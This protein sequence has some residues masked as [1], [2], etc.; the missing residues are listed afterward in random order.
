[1]APTSEHRDGQP[2]RS[3]VISGPS[4][5]VKDT[6]IKRL[7]DAHPS[8][9]STI[10]SHTTRQKRPDEKEGVDY[11]FISSTQFRSMIHWEEFVEHTIYNGH[12]YGTSERAVR[13]EL[14]IGGTLLLDI[15][16]GGVKSLQRSQSLNP[17]YVFIRPPNLDALKA[18][19]KA[20]G[21]EDEESIKG[22]LAEAEAELE[23]AETA[24]IFDMI[25]INDD[26]DEAYRHLE[27]FACDNNYPG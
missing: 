5:V 22:R 20:R 2:N 17:R 8:K 21:T 15:N 26:L 6:L 10:V 14:K 18:R 13:L 19:L 1:M 24:G 7:K 27:E 25:I 23:F 3:I 12:H 11:C 16:I 9:F 4:G